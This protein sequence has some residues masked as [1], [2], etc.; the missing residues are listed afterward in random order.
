MGDMGDIFRDM[1]EANRQ[2]RERNLKRAQDSELPWM[3]HTDHHWSLELQGDRL[4]YWPSTQ[5]FRWRGKSYQ[6]GVEGFIRKRL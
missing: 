5:K 4:D 6:G 2:R 3:K 1:R